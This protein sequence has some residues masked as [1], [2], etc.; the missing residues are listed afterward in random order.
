M[1]GLGKKT[2][3]AGDVLIAGDVNNYLMDQTVMNFA[4]SAA[5]S[6]AIP[7]PSTGMTS[8]RSDINQIESY[9]GSAWR[10]PTGLQLVK[11]QTVS[12]GVASVTI[13]DCFNAQYV[14]YRVLYTGGVASATGGSLFTRG[15]SGTGNNVVFAGEFVDTTGSR[16]GLG[17]G[18]GPFFTISLTG[19]SQITA[20]FDVA[21]PFLP[22][23]TGYTSIGFGWGVGAG[24][25]TNTAGSDNQS[26][27]SSGLIIQASSGTITGG[28][29]YVYGYGA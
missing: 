17:S 12:A 2:F 26:I 6:S 3:T 20:T 14:N 23:L 19:T 1:P 9:D 15:T 13:T 21:Q 5:R 11:K 16:S 28:T 10:G 4:T 24:Y 27:S 29:V 25:M 18:A 8:Y 22:A 7:V